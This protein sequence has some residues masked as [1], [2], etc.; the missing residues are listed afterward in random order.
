MYK[1]AHDPHVLVGMIGA[2]SIALGNFDN[3]GDLDAF[4]GMMSG[5]PN[6]L[7]RS[8]DGTFVDVAVWTGVGNSED[9]QVYA[10]DTSTLLGTRVVDTRTGYNSD[11]AAL[12][13]FHLPD[14]ELVHL[15]LTEMTRKGTGLR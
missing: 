9:G 3:D 12:A 13:H 14:G 10:R 15:E 11:N 5:Q 2:V 6:S 1:V 8:D 4:V 7:Y